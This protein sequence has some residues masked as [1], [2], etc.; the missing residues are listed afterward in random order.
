MPKIFP[1]EAAGGKKIGHIK[2]IKRS[3]GQHEWKAFK[4]V[5]AKRTLLIEK[6]PV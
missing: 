3:L 4:K 6:Y 1:F 5:P 2:S